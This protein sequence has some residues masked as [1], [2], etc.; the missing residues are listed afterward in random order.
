MS[1]KAKIQALVESGL[2]ENAKEARAM[3]IDMGEIDG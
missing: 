2:A 3:L 1:I